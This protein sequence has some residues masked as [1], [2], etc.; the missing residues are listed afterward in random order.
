MSNKIYEE[1]VSHFGGQ[2]NTAFA[3]GI[4]QPTVSGYLNG[5]WNM[6]PIVAIR[7]EKATFG[8]FKAVDLCPALKEFENLSA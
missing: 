3:L 2:V 1:L 5:R 8:K 6:P 7:A 4:A